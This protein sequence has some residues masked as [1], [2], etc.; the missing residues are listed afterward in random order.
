ML[1]GR[2]KLLQR[3]Q[4][5]LGIDE[6]P[7]AAANQ[8]LVIDKGDADGVFF[9]QDS[10]VLCVGD[11][12]GDLESAA[13]DRR[14]FHPAIVECHA[15]GHASQPLADIRSAERA[16]TPAIVRNLQFS[17]RLSQTRLNRCL[18]RGASMLDHVG[19]RFLDGAVCGQFGTRRQL[20]AWLARLSELNIQ[21]CFAGC[22]EKILAG[23]RPEGPGGG[24]VVVA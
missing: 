9:Q 24:F 14:G 3:L 18:D 1:P 10:L 20:S 11:E 6:H 5:G 21:T 12:Y 8:Q 19:E 2:L 22:V 7:E 13:G 17:P 23:P 4:V 15:F 16:G